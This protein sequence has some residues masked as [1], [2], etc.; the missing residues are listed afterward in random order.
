M[1]YVYHQNNSGGEFHISGW[2]NRTVAIEADSADEAN[3]RAAL[4]GIYFDGVQKGLDCECCGD[5]WNRFDPAWQ[6]PVRRP[7]KGPGVAI[8]YKVG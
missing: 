5:R 2:V 6:K 3:E 8:H 4:R 1:F 7:P